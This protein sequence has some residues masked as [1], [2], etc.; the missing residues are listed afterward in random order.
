MFEKQIEAAVEKALDRRTILPDK[1][2]VLDGYNPLPEIMGKLYEWLY[3]PFH[4]GS[5]TIKFFI[6][7]ETVQ[8]LYTYG[9]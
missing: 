7:V 2:L 6:F 1:K 3:I 5:L 9:A 8:P 4:T